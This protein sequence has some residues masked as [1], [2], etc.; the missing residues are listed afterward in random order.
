MP[1]LGLDTLVKHQTA[2]AGHLKIL[3]VVALDAFA[4]RQAIRS[5]I[6]RF[7][8]LPHHIPSVFCLRT[9]NKLRDDSYGLCFLSF[10]CA[11]GPQSMADQATSM[12]SLRPGGVLGTQVDTQ[13]MASPDHGALQP[14]PHLVTSTERGELSPCAAGVIR[15]HQ[16]CALSAPADI[17][18]HSY[19]LQTRRAPFAP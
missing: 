6:V 16:P 10:L 3:P 7:H 9:W 14:T 4:R 11:R 2:A 18:S 17:T 8:F 19:H 13:E 12:N 1:V 15:P 5:H